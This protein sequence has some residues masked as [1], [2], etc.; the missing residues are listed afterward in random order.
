MSALLRCNW[1]PVANALA[2]AQPPVPPAP[3]TGHRARLAQLPDAQRREVAAVMV[4]Q[5]M[6]A[7]GLEEDEDEEQDAAAAAALTQ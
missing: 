2:C 7:M 6:A 4:M 5:L 3:S 1:A